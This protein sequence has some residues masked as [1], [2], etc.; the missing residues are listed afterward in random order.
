[1]NAGTQLF[2]FHSA[3]TPAHRVVLP[4]FGV[5]SYFSQ[6]Y[7]EASSQTYTGVCFH[8]DSEHRQVGHQCSVTPGV[9]VPVCDPSTQTEVG[10]SLSPLE[11]A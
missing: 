10:G 9:V 11:P 8:G 2:S 6:P 4:I 5:S 1:M 7:L 3:Q